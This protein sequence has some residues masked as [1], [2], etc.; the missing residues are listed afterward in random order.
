[1]QRETNEG[2]EEHVD[3]REMTH[4]VSALRV[5]CLFFF[6]FFFLM[7]RMDD[8]Q[9]Q[10]Q[11]SRSLCS[12]EASLAA[13]G[14]EEAQRSA[15]NIRLKQI[16]IIYVWSLHLLVWKHRSAL[17]HAFYFF[18]FLWMEKKNPSCPEIKVFFLPIYDIYWILHFLLAPWHLIF[19]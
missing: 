17:L 19:I 15:C 7:S 4:V 18:I 13:G 3:H 14:E 6:L 10:Q 5:Q 1:M 12:L 9:R 2:Q 11:T 16:E 8:W